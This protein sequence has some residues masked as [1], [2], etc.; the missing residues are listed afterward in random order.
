MTSASANIL[1]FEE[2]YLFHKGIWSAFHRGSLFLQKPRFLFLELRAC[3][4]Y[5]TDDEMALGP[6]RKKN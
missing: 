1:K 4:L 2:K 3:A 6:T 5:S